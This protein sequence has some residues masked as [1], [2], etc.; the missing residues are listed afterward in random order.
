MALLPD[1]AEASQVETTYQDLPQPTM[2]YHDRWIE[3]GR[4]GILTLVSGALYVQ[5]GV[6]RRFR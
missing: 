5:L 4:E 1:K 2:T 6:N 3:I